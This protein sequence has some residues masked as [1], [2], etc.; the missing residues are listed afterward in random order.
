MG[1]LEQRLNGLTLLFGFITL[2]ILVGTLIVI[3][4]IDEAFGQDADARYY[5]LE[6]QYPFTELCD[7]KRLADQ[8]KIKDII[9]VIC[10]IDES[11]CVTGH[12][13]DFKDD[14]F[15]LKIS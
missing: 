1:E 2:F 8:Q 13:Q 7:E 4:I 9:Q 3:G 10:D 12:S 15:A 14:E 5:C 6:H 11:Y